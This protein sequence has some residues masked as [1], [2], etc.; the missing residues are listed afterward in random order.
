TSS[1]SGPRCQETMRDATAQTRRVKRLEKKKKSRTHGLKILYKVGLSTR[2]ELSAEE[3]SLDEE[4]A[5]KHGRNIA[6]IDVDAKTTLVDETTE[7]QGRY[8][9][10]EMFDT[11]VLN[12]EEVVIKKA[13]AVKEV[14]AAQ[15]QVSV[16]TTTTAKDLTV[17][18]ITLA[19]VL[20]ALKTSK[21]K[22]TGIVVRDHEEPSKSKTTTTPTSVADST[23]PKAKGIVMKEHSEET[24][25]TILIPTQD[26]QQESTKKQKVYDDQE[27]AELKRC[28]E[29][30][31]DD[32][33][34]VTI[35][36]T[37]LSFK[38]PT[39][40]D[41]KIHKEGRKSYFQ[42]IRADGSSQMYYTFSKMLKN[43]N[44]EDLKLLW[45]IVKAR[46]EK[47]QPVNDLDCYLL[48]TLKSMFEH[49]VED[50]VWKNQQGLAKVKNWKL[51]DSCGVHCVSM[52][53]TAYYLLVEKMYPL[54]NYTLTQML[55]DVRLQVNYEV[56]M[57]YDLPIL[58]L[59]DS[60]N[61]HQVLGR[62]VGIKN[63]HEVTA[64]DPQD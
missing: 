31:P 20:K 4:D 35:N 13:V 9:D 61:E 34:E 25:T 23:R 17:D 50:S 53:N 41:Y 46:F 27:A 48:H 18:D 16:A 28:L 39:I 44:R 37:P 62:I 36:D 52:Q 51:I 47:V 21:P 19:K 6:D 30:V 5:S 32:E 38:S 59:E 1:G 14:D 33:D 26:L 11:E 42:I 57:A 22:I 63:L 24:T 64:V 49:H 54:T 29:I 10:Q 55:N 7:D 60:E 8:N 3:Q 12:D 40:I 2:M 43:F 56:K 58:K 15:D 45:S